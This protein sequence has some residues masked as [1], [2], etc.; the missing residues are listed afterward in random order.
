[1]QGRINELERQKAKG[2]VLKERLT[3]IEKELQTGK[4]VERATVTQMLE[5]AD[6]ILIFPEFMEIVFSLSKVTGIESVDIPSMECESSIKI[7]YGNLFS[8]K[9]QKKKEREVI[10]DIMRKNPRI[11]ARM[12]A[13][14]LEISLSGANYRIRALKR[15]GRIR[16]VGSGG[17]GEW[18]IL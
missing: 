12:I 17:K 10:V 7:E 6:K 16:F 14:E 5:E 13:K 4:A 1:M 8:Y 15:E 11:T 9:E 18:E 3:H 2:S